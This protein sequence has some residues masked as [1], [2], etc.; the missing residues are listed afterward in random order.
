MVLSCGMTSASYISDSCSAQCQI[1][2]EF[3]VGKV[4]HVNNADLMWSYL[5]SDFIVRHSSDNPFRAR[6]KLQYS[7]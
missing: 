5:R 2:V 7:K 3:V 1:M 4:I 6:I